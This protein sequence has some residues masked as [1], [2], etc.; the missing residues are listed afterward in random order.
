MASLKEMKKWIKN[1]PVG[2]LIRTFATKKEQVEKRSELTV[3][4]V[5]KMMATKVAGQKVFAGG[6][7]LIFA[8]KHFGDRADCGQMLPALTETIKHEAVVVEECHHGDLFCGL[9]NLGLVRTANRGFKWMFAISPE[10]ASYMNEKNMTKLVEAAM[11]GAKAIG[12]AINE[13][14]SS[15]FEGCITNTF[16]M[17]NVEALFTVG[18]YDLMA[19]MAD[20]PNHANWKRGWDSEK[21]FVFYPSQG[22]EEIP[23]LCRMIKVYGQCIATI[24]PSQ[25][26]RA[27]YKLPTNPA[28]LER[29]IAKMSAKYARQISMAEKTGF[30]LSYIKGGILDGYPK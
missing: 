6:N 4:I 10:A 22:V 13:L 7:V 8:D 17:W 2:F 12:L 28:L 3:N 11:N 15:I 5:E 27:K 14:Q 20:D 26:N 30:D 25:A 21:G 1:N 29:H 23:A 19:A 16:A 24:L 9:G 18:G